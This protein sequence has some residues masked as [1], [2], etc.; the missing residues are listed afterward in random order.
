MGALKI[1]SN[2]KYGFKNWHLT[3]TEKKYY[4]KKYKSSRNTIYT[5]FQKQTLQ[6][7]G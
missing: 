3:L 2:K 7:A 1:A 6:V 5:F 4:R